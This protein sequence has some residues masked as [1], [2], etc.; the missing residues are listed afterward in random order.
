[1][2]EFIGKLEEQ[3]GII[4]G[5]DEEIWNATIDRVAVDLEERIKIYFKDGK[6]VE[7]TM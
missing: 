4:T 7:G 5:F 1:M 2:K 3:E 6:I